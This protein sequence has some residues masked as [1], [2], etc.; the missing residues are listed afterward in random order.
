MPAAVA[1]SWQSHLGRP[2]VRLATAT[3]GSCQAVSLQETPSETFTTSAT[4]ILA[5][6][7]GQ[8]AHFHHQ[9]VVRARHSQREMIRRAN[10]FLVF[11]RGFRSLRRALLSTDSRRSLRSTNPRH[12]PA[13]AIPS[14]RA[15]VALC[16]FTFNL[17]AAMSNRALS[18]RRECGQVNA[19]LAL[20]WLGVH[21]PKGN[22]AGTR[23]FSQALARPP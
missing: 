21:C 6:G 20:M 12:S 3:S 9:H 5:L 13:S 15:S 14:F 18:G 19:P 11:A 22:F 4:V 1:T 23:P 16:F 10:D 7:P 17:L 2:M 8:M